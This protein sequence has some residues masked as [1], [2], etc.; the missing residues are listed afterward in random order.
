M[1]GAAVMGTSSER[2]RAVVIAHR[3]ASAVAPENTRRAIEVAIEAG[4]PVIEFDVRE[5]VDGKLVLFH[6]DSLER[7]AGRKGSVETSRWED[8][9]SLDVGKWF[10]K[11]EFAGEK[12]FLFEDAIALCGDREVTALVEHKSGKPENYAGVIREFGSG[13]KIIVQSF[14]W[15]FL[16]A[17]RREMPEVPIGALGSKELSSDRVKKLER[18]RSDWVGW[19]HSDLTESNFERLRALGFRIALYTVNE[20]AEAKL[21]IDRGADG[22]IT[23]RPGLM[24]P[25][26]GE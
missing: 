16:G 21:W 8:I 26:T 10:G 7:I 9:V 20:P 13:E 15:E 2:E 1:A 4:A 18:L 23:D 12:P 19:K 17:F 6:D 3:G 5:T 14:D 22:I 24:L 11:G 25:L